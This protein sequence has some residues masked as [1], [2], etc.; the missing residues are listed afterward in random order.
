MRKAL[1]ALSFMVIAALTRPA[2]AGGLLQDLFARIQAPAPVVY[3]YAPPQPQ[4]RFVNDSGF[5]VSRRFYTTGRDYRGNRITLQQALHR[6]AMKQKASLAGNQRRVSASG[7]LAATASSP[8]DRTGA[9][10]AGALCCRNGEDAGKSIQQDETLRVGDAYMTPEG[11]KIYRGRAYGAARPAFVDYRQAG[12]DKTLDARLA[13]FTRHDGLRG[14]VRAQPHSNWTPARAA[15]TADGSRGTP[16]RTS[17]DQTGRV[18]RVV[19][20]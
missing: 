5:R 18:I 16:T 10:R 20:P 11:L 2:H 15:A 12:V 19:G 8:A 14:A 1:F 7:A 13:E 9:S 6:R 4:M 17:I 3:A